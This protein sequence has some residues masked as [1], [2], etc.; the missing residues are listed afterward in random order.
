MIM[1]I[2]ILTTQVNLTKVKSNFTS[3]ISLLS[4]TT[5]FS[6]FLFCFHFIIRIFYSIY[7]T[8][9]TS[10]DWSKSILFSLCLEKD[11]F[12]KNHL[13][14]SLNEQD[15]VWRLAIHALCHVPEYFGN[16]PRLFEFTSK[17]FGNGLK[18]VCLSQ[19]LRSPRLLTLWGLMH[20]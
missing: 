7:K 19:G 11:S 1:V 15:Y 10:R 18:H 12:S 2:T 20:R 4:L 3:F 6:H 8:R 16:M 9:M 13:L 5:W 14:S 17:I